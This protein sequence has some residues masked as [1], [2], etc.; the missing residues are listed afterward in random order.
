MSVGG[1]FEYYDDE[2]CVIWYDRGGCRHVFQQIT[3]RMDG[4]VYISKK[5]TR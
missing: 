1:L 3:E 5:G 4:C 2:L